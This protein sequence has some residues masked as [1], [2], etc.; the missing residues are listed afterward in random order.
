[1]RCRAPDDCIEIVLEISTALHLGAVPE[2]SV[3]Y[4]HSQLAASARETKFG[5][6]RTIISLLVSAMDLIEQQY[7]NSIVEI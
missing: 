3:P 2:P 1:M 4:N 6:R 7:Q 5:A